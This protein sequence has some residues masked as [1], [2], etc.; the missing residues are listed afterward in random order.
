MK[1]LNA[2]RQLLKFKGWATISEIAQ[3]AEVKKAIALEVVNKN[4]PFLNI[5]RK[6]G[7]VVGLLTFYWEQKTAFMASGKYYDVND[8]YGSTIVQ[9][10]N[11]AFVQ[12]FG[13][14]YDSPILAD[15]LGW[16]NEN[17]I[18]WVDSAPY[19]KLENVWADIG[20]DAPIA[21]R[22]KLSQLIGQRI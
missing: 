11:T 15:C 21:T 7:K 19:I 10:R 3:I 1:V 22:F 17:E 12:Q 2:I 5:D 18:G 16:L 4:L 20:E 13:P 14:R 8:Y 6:S 9:S